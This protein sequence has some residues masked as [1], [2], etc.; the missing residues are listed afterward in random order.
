MRIAERLYGSH[1]QLAQMRWRRQ[2]GVVKMAMVELRL[3]LAVNVDGCWPAM[4]RRLGL[5]G[6]ATGGTG[7]ADAGGDT[8]AATDAERADADTADADTRSE[9][10]GH[11][12][13]DD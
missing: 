6:A 1:G 12:D 5:A 2:H 3:R 8:S 10:A 9:D 11:D 4:A 13:W 7:A